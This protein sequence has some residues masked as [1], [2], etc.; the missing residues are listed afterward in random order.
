MSQQRFTVNKTSLEMFDAFRAYGLAA[1]LTCEE[2]VAHIN[3]L[4]YAYSIDVSGK[5]PEAPDALLFEDTEGW[6]RIF[7]TFRERKDSKKQHPRDNVKE[8]ATKEYWNIIELHRAP[9]FV[10]SIGC[11]VKDGRTLYQSLDVSASKGY[12]EGKRDV[13][14]EGTQLEVDK[15]SWAIACIGAA[16]S[17]VWRYGESF[18]LSLVPNPADVSLISHRTIQKDLDTR[19]CPISANATITHYSVRLA[20]LISERRQSL[21]VKYDSIIFN[22]MKK[23]GQ[24][25][26]PGGGGQYSLSFLDE[27]A[28]TPAGV[29]AL[30]E[31]ER[32]FPTSQHARGTKQSLALVL[33][34]FLLNPELENFRAFESLYIRGQINEELYPWEKDQLGEILKHVKIV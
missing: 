29:F 20:L 34:D 16:L 28:A 33:A 31:I 24:Q 11:R 25:P 8:L 12:R 6:N 32:K 14:H 18:I 21:R 5:M 23:T 3:D 27:L 10:P 17:G 7:G 22:I 13:Y 26:K 30:K 4:G 9:D 15:Y 2:S 19:V 1:L